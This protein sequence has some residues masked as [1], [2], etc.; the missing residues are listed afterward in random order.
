MAVERKQF[1]TEDLFI[2]RESDQ[3][4]Y[5]R[6]TGKI[7]AYSWGQRKLCLGK[8][9]AISLYS[10]PD[11][12][13]PV[14][15][16]T[17][18]YAGASPFHYWEIMHEFYGKIPGIQVVWHLYD[19]RPIV[20]P[21]NIPNMEVFQQLFTDETAAKYAGQSNVFFFSDIRTVDSLGIVRE[22]NKKYGIRLDA[23]GR[24]APNNDRAALAS[25]QLEANEKI[26]TGI[27]EDMMRQQRWVQI[28]NPEH[29][30]LK[31]RLPYVYEN[32]PG[33]QLNVQYLA[34]EI[35]LQPWAKKKST[36]T[37]LHPTRNQ[38]GQY[39]LANWSSKEYESLL[40][41]HNINVRVKKHYYNPLAPNDPTKVDI[42]PPEL[43]SDWDSCAE[44]Q[45]L[46]IYC[47]RMGVPIESMEET[48]IEL[49]KLITQMLNSG[50]GKDTTLES[51]RAISDKDAFQNVFNRGK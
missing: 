44:A 7:M 37:R 11:P 49:S 40:A 42:D 16:I 15:K 23:H 19:P 35:L 30:F 20:I 2:N 6:T 18:V 5:T 41:H 13:Q 17:I 48:V 36:E 43:F 8:I 26:E 14:T 4:E 34:G 39:F 24:P 33:D 31:M 21:K 22:A 46:K 51:I 32:T 9:L 28:M 47:E 45:I 3:T 1:T 27:L 10:T 25:A 38:D 29:A 12:R 50:K